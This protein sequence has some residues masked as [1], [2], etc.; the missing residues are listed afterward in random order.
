MPSWQRR[1]LLCCLLFFLLQKCALGQVR[2]TF[3]EGANV[4]GK[5]LQVSIINSNKTS[6]T[7]CAEFGIA[8]EGK[9]TPLPFQI[10]RQHNRRW[11]LVLT[12]PDVGSL[13]STVILEAS[14]FRTFQI[15]AKEPGQYKLRLFYLKRATEDARCPLE[16]AV[17]LDS[18]V[19]T[20]T[21]SRSEK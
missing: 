2:I 16:S 5:P 18:E 1:M 6:I 14:E 20:V 9:V 12:S 8:F 19:F 10:L 17:R 13:N 4:A 3:Q 7:F 21:K 11:D 15:V